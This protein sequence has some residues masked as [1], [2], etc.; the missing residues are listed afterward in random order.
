MDTVINIIMSYQ[1]SF[2]HLAAAAGIFFVIGYIR[3][4]N[5]LKELARTIYEN[6]Q[7][8][9]QLNEE[10]LF[11]KKETPVIEIQQVSQKNVSMRK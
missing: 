11:G 3:G 2:I 9:F 5:K 4:K 6:E 8:I 7:I 10:L 1:F